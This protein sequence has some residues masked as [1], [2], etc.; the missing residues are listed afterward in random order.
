MPEK[1]KGPLVLTVICAVVSALLIMVHN[2]TYVDTTGIITDELKKGLEEIYGPGEYHMLKAD[3][4]SVLKFNGIN[5][6]ITDDSDNTAFEITA[7]GY[8]KNGIHV[9]IGVTDEG[10]S[11]ISVIDLAET[12]GVGTRIRDDKKFI[13]QFIG[14]KDENYEFTALTGATYS[15]KGMKKAVDTALKAYDELKKEEVSEN[16]Q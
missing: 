2:L 5:S 14:A 10:V 3:D 11:G 8:T 12:S 7:D 1:I 9:L 4:G 15:S 16:E 13:K 6:V